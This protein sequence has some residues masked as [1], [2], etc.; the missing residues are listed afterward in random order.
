MFC[1]FSHGLFISTFSCKDQTTIKVYLPHYTGLI[2]FFFMV[3]PIWLPLFSLIFIGLYVI[4]SQHH[5]HPS[6]I[7]F[8]GSNSRPLDHE[9]SALTTRPWLL[10]YRTY[11]MVMPRLK[12][13]CVPK[14]GFDWGP[15][16]CKLYKLASELQC[17]TG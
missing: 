1:Y 16:K 17:K 6:S 8:W 15:I 10:A 5:L 11:S 3:C 4:A 14:S 9:S 13:S 12:N 2:V 7:R